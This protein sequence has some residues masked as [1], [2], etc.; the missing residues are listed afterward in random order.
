MCVCARRSFDVL[1]I[2]QTNCGEIACT[3]GL[4]EAQECRSTD[5]RPAAAYECP[6][7]CGVSERSHTA[8]VC[9]L[10]RGTC[11]VTY[12]LMSGP[13]CAKVCVSPVSCKV[14][15]L[16]GAAGW[17]GFNEAWTLSAPSPASVC[18]HISV[19]HSFLLELLKHLFLNRDQCFLLLWTYTVVVRT[20]PS[21][22]CLVSEQGSQQM[23]DYQ[24]RLS[25]G[26][27]M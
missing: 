1:P 13:K 16:S 14:F 10:T 4:H 12:Q 17:L 11:F 5:E 23:Q 18:L 15:G 22:D 25:F 24:T 6:C 27:I 21:A 9:S 2:F 26:N 20:V 7:A 19:S 3:N 8:R